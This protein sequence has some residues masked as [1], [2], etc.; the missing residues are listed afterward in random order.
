MLITATNAQLV[1]LS[2]DLVFYWAFRWAKVRSTFRLK[3]K[4]KVIFAEKIA[5][6]KLQSVMGLP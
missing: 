2:F 3:S 6:S 5:K 1:T 4:S